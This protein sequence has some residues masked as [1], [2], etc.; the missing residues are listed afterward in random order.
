M[1]ELTIARPMARLRIC[2]AKDVP[3]LKVEPRPPEGVGANVSPANRT[4]TI[5]ATDDFSPTPAA[6]LAIARVVTVSVMNNPSS[7]KALHATGVG[8]PDETLFL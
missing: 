7:F 4:L 1:V 5:V 3:K 8:W 6:S 2:E